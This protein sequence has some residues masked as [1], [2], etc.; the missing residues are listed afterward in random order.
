MPRVEKPF[1][2]PMDNASV[3]M[4][5]GR[6]VP[7]AEL[8]AELDSRDQRET[9]GLL[10]VMGEAQPPVIVPTEQAAPD[11][12]KKAP[13]LRGHFKQLL[14]DIKNTDASDI[15]AITNANKFL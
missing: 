4:G 12:V 2:I 11:A 10:N 6:W 14:A 13:T 3:P 15:E 9:P 7:V 1:E 8:R 5:D